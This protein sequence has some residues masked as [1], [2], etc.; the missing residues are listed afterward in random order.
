MN[1]LHPKHMAASERVGEIAEI[2]VAGLMRLQARQSSGLSNHTGE[3]SLDCVA[4]QSGHAN[5]LKRPGG[6]E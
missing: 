4:H 1:A 2:L 3:S 5:A 6:L